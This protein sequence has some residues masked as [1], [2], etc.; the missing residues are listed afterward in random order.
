MRMIAITV[1]IGSSSVEPGPA[2]D[3]SASLP[4]AVVIVGLEAFCNGDRSSPSGDHTVKMAGIMRRGG[5]QVSP[6]S[7][8]SPVPGRE[9]F[10]HEECERE[11]EPS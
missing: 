10:L 8:F 3:T 11:A 2:N 5:R 1:F 7:S 9:C 4:V 6:C